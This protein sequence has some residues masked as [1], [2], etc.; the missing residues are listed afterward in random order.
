MRAWVIGLVLTSAGCATP[1]QES[2]STADIRTLASI[3]MEGR[4][5]GEHRLGT[6]QGPSASDRPGHRGGNARLSDRGG[7][8]GE[9]S[10]E[11]QALPSGT[12]AGLQRAVPAC[13]PQE[14]GTLL[15]QS[16][17]PKGTEG[18]DTGNPGRAATGPAGGLS[19]KV[20]QVEFTP[21]YAL[22]ENSSEG[23]S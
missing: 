15:P 11:G 4:G 10:G 12:S 13:Q 21:A 2:T 14:N 8:V 6:A 3:V 9:R 23:T 16:A 1:S 17:Q 7:V 18:A 19:G 5:G 22:E 20:E